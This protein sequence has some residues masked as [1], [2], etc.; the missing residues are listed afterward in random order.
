MTDAH[1]AELARLL[2]VTPDELAARA[3]DLFERESSRAYP[4]P[5]VLCGAGR[6]G[7]IV[8][9]GLRSA[10]VDVVAF[11]DNDPRLHGREVDECDVMS[12]DEAVRRHGRRAVFVTTIYTARPLREQ[13]TDAGVPVAS[14]R[15]VFFQHPDVFLPHASVDRPES[16]VG[17][18][19][20]IV[21]GLSCWADEASR[22]DYVAQIAW[23][24]LASTEVP[25]WVPAEETYFPE[26]LVRL[27]DHEVFVDC[28]GFDGDTLRAFL[29][30]KGDRFDRLIAFE[31]DPTN[32]EA[33]ESFIAGL[34]RDVRDRIATR[35]VAV[36][37]G[38]ETLRFA[39]ADGAGSAVAVAG[40]VEVE[41]DSLDNL[42]DGIAPTFI[43][44]DIE[45]AEP[46]AI[47]G[48]AGTLRASAPTLA[49][50]L[51]HAR[52][53]L[54]QL[55]KAIREANP[56]YAIYLRR[57]SDECWENVAYALPG[58]SNVIG[59]RVE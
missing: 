28:G 40:D 13:L 56:D 55:P 10:G 5:L 35:R 30:R 34:P 44:M 33:L 8:L 46:D 47:R 17:Q 20:D 43:K 31:P 49:I 12:I 1:A 27:G 6:L 14:A 15:S 19:P 41:A 45:G 9:R 53:H 37:S 29:S 3:N 32:F 54:W 7:R 16:I 25:P 21:E 22:A 24:S 26:G 18:A 38:R 36:H 4:A 11:A 23:H 48:A 2:D 42:L 52:E 39:A 59:V 57:H 58:P 50:C 51:Y